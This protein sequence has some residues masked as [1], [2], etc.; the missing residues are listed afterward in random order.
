MC[1]YS[2]CSEF[3]HPLHLLWSG[4]F[5]SKNFYPNIHTKN[6]DALIILRYIC[7]GEKILA[8]AG[9]PS[10]PPLPRL[11][12]PKCFTTVGPYLNQGPPCTTVILLLFLQTANI[13][14][15]LDHEL[16]L[17]FIPFMPLRS[18]RPLP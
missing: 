6:H 14:R 3:G 16:A 15:G 18:P 9:P 1:V 13:F 8:P 11:D 12:P 10:S 4:K 7:W 5:F 2:K 17:I